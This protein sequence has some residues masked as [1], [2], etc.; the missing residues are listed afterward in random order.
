MPVYEIDLD[1]EASLYDP[2]YNSQSAHSLK[3]IKEFEYIFFLLNQQKCTLK[4]KREYTS[5]YLNHLRQLGFT[6]PL[7]N[8]NAENAIPFWGHH[9]D[10]KIEQMLNSKLL[11]C[12]IAKNNEW[13][14]EKGAIVTSLEELE[15]HLKFF[16]EI[17][18]WILKS[19]VSFSG[20]GH[21]SFQVAQLNQKI[22]EEKLK[23]PML[24]EPRFDRL[25][26]IG[27]T[28]VISEGE[29]KAVFMVENFNSAHGAF[30]GGMAC[31]SNENFLKQI[32]LKYEF[33][34]SEL[35]EIALAIGK[36]YIRRGAR[37]NVQIDSFIYKEAG[38]LKLYPLVEVN[39]RKTMG[40]VLSAL[41][42]KFADDKYIEW[43]I[44]SK[45]ELA[46]VKLPAHAIELSPAG[47][48]FRSF[49]IVADNDYKV[50]V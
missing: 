47:N 43:K 32:K 35:Y 24:L 39:Y 9:H 8:P 42:D 3:T 10:R 31:T 6:I 29:V 16:P 36:E 27:T 1:Y 34:L 41:A 22:L 50:P 19:P 17:A 38:K 4:N 25:F 46:E 12:E 11:S 45:K 20:I 49:L 21:Y 13:G 28:L 2:A 37:H 40:L 18:S 5:D 7:L 33:D 14:F 30:R 15:K 23:G 48:T 44:F 26:D